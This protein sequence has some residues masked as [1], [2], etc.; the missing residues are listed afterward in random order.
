[1]TKFTIIIETDKNFE[2][3]MKAISK[4]K[5]KYLEPTSK[6]VNIIEGGT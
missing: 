6:I 5:V 2:E 1:M 4:L 3:V